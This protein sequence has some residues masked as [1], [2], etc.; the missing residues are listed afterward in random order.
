MWYITEKLNRVKRR[1]ESERFITSD[2]TDRKVY[3]EHTFFGKITL[4]GFSTL[5]DIAKLKYN[6]DIVKST[7]K[8]I[9]DCIDNRYTD[10]WASRS[11]LVLWQ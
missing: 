3:S 9:L 4:D 1:R 5:D 10:A 8:F 7:A 2:T 6:P 11:S